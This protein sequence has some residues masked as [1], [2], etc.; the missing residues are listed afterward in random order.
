MQITEGATYA[1]N[2]TED[3]PGTTRTRSAKENC[4]APECLTRILSFTRSQSEYVSQQLGYLAG[5]DL[6]NA[7]VEGRLTPSGLRKLFLSHIHEPGVAR[8]QYFQLISRLQ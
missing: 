1:P 4:R 8:E 6:Y 3:P 7:Y 5:N 2:R